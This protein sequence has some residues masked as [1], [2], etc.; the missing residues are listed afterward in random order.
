[1]DIFSFEKDASAIKAG[2]WVS[3]IPGM[4]D[5]RLKVRGMN[6]PA[7]LAL[8]SRKE[9]KVGRDGRE[10]DGSLK[11]AERLRITCEVLHEAVLID[12]DGLTEG[13][14]PLPYS[15]EAAG[16]YLLNPNFEAFADAVTYAAGVVDQGRGE[17]S[18]DLAKN[19]KAPSS[20]D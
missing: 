14:K 4:G 11:P 1:M 17:T 16:K 19:S 5:A 7:A 10:R 3:D 15:I 13:G 12:W 20:G 9:R 18:E 6:S 8:R 2:Q